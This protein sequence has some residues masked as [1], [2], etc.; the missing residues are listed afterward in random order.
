MDLIS[1]VIPVY[2]VE[3]YLQ[4][5]VT[6]VTEQSYSN[7][8]IILVDDG[9]VD[10]SGAICD[11]FA[12]K[13]KRI[14]VIHKENEGLGLTRNVGIKAATGNYICF[15]D[16]DDYIAREYIETIYSDLKKSSADVC[17]CG[18]TKDISGKYEI[19]KNPLA[20]KVY[21]GNEI[22]EKVIPRM[23]GCRIGND[24]IEMSSC[25]AIYS[26]NLIKK[27]VLAFPSEREFISEDLIFNI[28]YLSQCD[29]IRISD[30]VGYFY[31]TVESSL[32]RK[33]DPNRLSKQIVMTQKVIELTKKIGVF[34]LCEERIYNNF[35]TW[36]RAIIK[37]E[38]NRYL[39]IGL[40]NSIAKIFDICNDDYVRKISDSF[41]NIGVKKS[42]KVVNLMIKKRKVKLLWVIMFIKNKWGV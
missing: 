41:D 38:Q 28:N 11:D 8:E 10:K 16:S 12:K 36:V 42:S 2:N 29:K 31:V 32:T 33:Y 20:G 6:S 22:K 34:N 14:R 35:L 26:T 39:E 30:N 21:S 23:C 17:Y 4:R 9:S 5:C 13:D 7:L 19:R 24:N 18:H 27:N 1:V 3:K 40:K 37:A 25:M 15:I